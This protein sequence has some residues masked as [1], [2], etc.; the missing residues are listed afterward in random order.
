M[1]KVFYVCHEDCRYDLI[2]S[3][4]GTARG[5]AF[6]GFMSRGHAQRAIDALN[7]KRV[8]GRPIAVDWAV[9]KQQHQAQALPEDA[10]GSDLDAED[11]ED[12]EDFDREAAAAGP[13]ASTVGS[14]V[15]QV[16]RE[17]GEDLGDG[18]VEEHEDDSEDEEE[19]LVPA[20]KVVQPAL[21]RTSDG[22][23]TAF[24]R[25]LPLDATSRQLSQRLGA[26]G[27]VTS[28]RLV[29]DKAAGGQLKGT[30]F[31]E[32]AT[33]EGVAAAV[34]ASD[35]ARCVCKHTSVVYNTL[36]PRT[37]TG[38]A[39]T[40]AGRMITVHAAL[41]GQQARDLATA[42]D[43]GKEDRRR[44]HLVRMRLILYVE[45]THVLCQAK[46]GV[47]VE[48]SPAWLDLSK[49]DQ[50]KRKRAAAEKK[51]KL[52]SPNYVVSATRLAVRNLPKSLDD[53]ALKQLFLQAVRADGATLVAAFHLDGTHRCK[54]GRPLP[55]R[56][57]NRPRSCVKPIAPLPTAP[58]GP[59]ASGLWSLRSTSMRC[60]HC[61]SS[62]TTQTSLVRWFCVLSRDQHCAHLGA[63][64]R[65]I[66][67][68]AIDSVKA[69]KAR[70]ARG[71]KHVAEGRRKGR[72]G[73]AAAEGGRKGNATAAKDAAG[74]E[75]KGNA[76][77]AKDAAGKANA[78]KAAPEG[79]AVHIKGKRNPASTPKSAAPREAVRPSTPEPVPPEAATQPNK[80]QRPASRKDPPQKKLAKKGAE[81]ALD[82][83]V[84]RYKAAMFGGA[85]SQAITRKTKGRWFD[86]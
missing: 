76:T 37:G 81:D 86:A 70:E 75:H 83:M 51:A 74:K 43:A 8:G 55:G 42:R 47:I 77:A 14:I 40:V 22:G 73:K 6:L 54:R 21:D 23:C 78:G 36:W 66:V 1:R 25:G 32:F 53:K 10:D 24:V 19:E 12:H 84:A 60:V 68:F 18:D 15:D 2:R 58:N 9:A 39:I 82:D 61:G 49:G 38:P 80:R 57:C 45:K 3:F 30:A 33:P 34:A 31:V 50:L 28:C 41:S 79:A 44:L 52:A 11:L 46:E 56:W 64:R 63:E 35:K 62:T 67:E 65:P 27:A 4:A 26:F 69:L 48:G 7:G 72:D 20:A 59:G 17:G 5:F 16:L 85:A 13:V 71:G 29:R